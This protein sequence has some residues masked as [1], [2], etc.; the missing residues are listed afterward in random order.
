M[1]A[2]LN[3]EG[4]GDKGDIAQM[5]RR[6]AE[7]YEMKGEHDEAAKLKKSAEDIRREVQGSRFAQLPD[8]ESSYDLMIFHGD[9]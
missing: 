9:R 1:I 5:L 7:A 8:T 6:L 2:E 3:Q 4:R